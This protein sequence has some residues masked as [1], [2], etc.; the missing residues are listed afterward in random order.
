VGLL[1]FCMERDREG[2]GMKNRE[3][4]GVKEGKIKTG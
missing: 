1:F 3:K 4:D 2:E